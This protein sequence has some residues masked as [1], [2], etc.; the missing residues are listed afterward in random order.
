MDE[1]FVEIFA[2]DPR[3]K[4][5]MKITALTKDASIACNKYSSSSSLRGDVANCIKIQA[6]QQNRIL[7]D[8]SIV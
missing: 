2:A 5:A 4:N 1:M 3:S 6:S 8:K 7:V